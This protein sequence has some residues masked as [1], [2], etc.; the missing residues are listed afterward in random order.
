MGDPEHC[1][2]AMI[3]SAHDD[4]CVLITLPMPAHEGEPFNWEI[5]SPSDL[6][7]SLLT[8]CPRLAD[9][10]ASAVA[11]Y[12]PS[13]HVWHIVVAWDE[14]TPGNKLTLDNTRKVMVL[15]FSFLELGIEALQSAA[16]WITP[17]LARSHNIHTVQGGWSHM[18]ACF[19]HKL[20]L[21]AKGFASV[22]VVLPIH[23]QSVLV[24][25]KL[26]NLLSDGE[27][28]QIAL[29]WKGAG[30]WKPCLRHFNVT[31]KESGFEDDTSFVDITCHSLASMHAFTVQGLEDAADLVRDA[32][33]R[34][35][36]N[37]LTKRMYENIEMANGLNYNPYGLLWDLTLRPHVR[38][39]DIITFDWVHSALQDG[40]LAI[41]MFLFIDA[42][43]RKLGTRWEDL[44][45]Y[46]HTRWEFPHML[47][48]RGRALHRI[49]SEWRTSENNN[50]MRATA[51]EL[52]GVYTLVR[53]WAFEFAQHDAVKAEF[54]SF[55]LACAVV[56]VIMMAK[57]C[58]SPARVRAISQKLKVLVERHMQ[59]HKAAHG[60]DRIKPKHH[61][62]FDL[63]LQLLRDGLVLD[64]FV[65]ERNH[66]GVKACAQHCKYLPSFERTVLRGSIL[67]Q[68]RELKE[69]VHNGLV[70]TR[71]PFPG[72]AGA[73]MSDSLISRGMT[74]CVDDIVFSSAN[75][76]GV[77]VAC[78]CESDV[79]LLVV[80][81][82]EPVK[83]L[84][85]WRPSSSMQVW[86]A[87][88]VQIASAWRPETQGRLTILRRFMT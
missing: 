6:L 1:I 38:V 2:D 19:L 3:R 72:V 74:V 69:L 53:H 50:K 52:L 44:E 62:M 84:Q 36:R 85:M 47:Q 9:A 32:H 61:W 63:I 37:A 33:G 67:N 49:F 13:L 12:P 29:D 28:L 23:A 48:H 76:P 42:C 5:A 41:D 15:S 30:S 27:G 21:G 8:D 81:C 73:D 80:Q 20:L 77:I 65:V 31:K 83:E 56:D 17:A 86:P 14:F 60:D 25:A 54:E 18:L 16:A 68:R 79:L 11:M 58:K 64:A 45:L 57:C 22:G 46:M 35:Q 4:C 34:W 39:A 66:L 7:V 82:M 10:Y 70:G 24:F 71:V 43:V 26:S 55:R 75:D 87:S 40:S 59:A 88:D 78:A 51:G